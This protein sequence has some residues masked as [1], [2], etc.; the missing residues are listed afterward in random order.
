MIDGTEKT[1]VV[2]VGDNLDIISKGVRKVSSNNDAVLVV[3]QPQTDGS[4]QFNAGGVV[5]GP[6]TAR[7]AVDGEGGTLYTVTVK[8]EL[9]EPDGASVLPPLT[10][11][12]SKTVMD[13]TVGDMLNVV[14]KDA[15]SVS[16]DNADVLQVSQP[17]SEG[18]PGTS[19][20]N[21]GARVIAPGTATLTVK[22]DT[23]TLYT[24][25]INAIAK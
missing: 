22:S 1:V 14:A 25:T 10:V 20:F 24:V 18:G 4:A 7:L 16:T 21:A 23:G 11:D 9:P 19:E 12:G 3:N 13:A 15:T 5:I 6:G 2:K 8:A 17:Y